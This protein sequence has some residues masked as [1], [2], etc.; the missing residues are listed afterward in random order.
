VREVK[1]GS[2]P[3]DEHSY[4]VNDAEYERF[5]SLLEKRRQH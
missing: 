5:L 2:F 3:D 4:G 1:E